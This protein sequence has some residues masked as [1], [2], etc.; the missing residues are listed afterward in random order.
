M[1]I[2]GF[3]AAEGVNFGKLSKIENLVLL[4]VRFIGGTK[5]CLMPPRLLVVVVG[6][7]FTT[8]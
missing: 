8:L 6:V 1:G 3:T 5:A 4:G 2:T 7:F